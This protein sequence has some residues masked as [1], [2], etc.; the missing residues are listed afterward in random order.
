LTTSWLKFSHVPPLL[1]YFELSRSSGL[2][3]SNLKRYFALLEATFPVQTLPAW[4]SNLSKRLTKSPKAL[5]GDT[6]LLAHTLG[7]DASR[8]AL[9]PELAGLL[10]ENFVLM[11]F[12][13]ETS[14]RP[15]ASASCAAS[16]SIQAERWSLSANVSTPSRSRRS[17]APD[18]RPDG[19]DF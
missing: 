7:L 14:P 11:E 17:G 5:F 16:S 9:E 8:L 3:Q 2:P 19:T 12:R 13:S 10:L 15:S 4:A 18:C 1:N 6:D